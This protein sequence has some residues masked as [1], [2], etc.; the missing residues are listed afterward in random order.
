MLN[1]FLQKTEEQ[2]VKNCDLYFYE[3]SEVNKAA[4]Y[5]LLNAGKRVRA[6]FIYLTAQM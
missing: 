3:D 2:L 5:S 4:R 6:M 1:K